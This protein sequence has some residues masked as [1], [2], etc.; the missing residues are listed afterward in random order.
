ME[1][2][3]DHLRD[4]ATFLK[5]IIDCICPFLVKDLLEFYRRVRAR[6]NDESTV[7]HASTLRELAQDLDHLQKDNDIEQARRWFLHLT[8]SDA[9]AVLYAI[10][11]RIREAKAKKRL[12]PGHPSTAVGTIRFCILHLSAKIEKASEASDQS[13]KRR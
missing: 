11:I 8:I 5:V 12:L 4:Y 3:F 1:M 7:Y 9:D 2:E 10:E 6:Q 13:D